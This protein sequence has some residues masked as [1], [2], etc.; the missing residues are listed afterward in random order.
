MKTTFTINSEEL[1]ENMIVLSFKKPIKFPKFIEFIE[2][3]IN[4]KEIKKNTESISFTFDDTEAGFV[5]LQSIIELFFEKHN[6]REI[7]DKSVLYDEHM[8]PIPRPKGKGKIR[9]LQKPSYLL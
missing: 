8:N 5:L 1:E 9:R 4:V 7:D 6:I 3:M 2:S